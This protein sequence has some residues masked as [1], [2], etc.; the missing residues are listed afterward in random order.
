[1]KFTYYYKRSDGVRR[2]G[3]I[4][5]SSRDDAFAALR[6]DGIRPIKVVADGASEVDG[7]SVRKGIRRGVL[8]GVGGVL[9]VVGVAFVVYFFLR[10]SRRNLQRTSPEGHAE[11]APTAIVPEQ[12]EETRSPTVAKPRPRKWLGHQQEFV[13]EQIFPHP[14]EAFLARFAEPGFM[15]A[16]PE[17]SF[18]EAVKEDLL[19]RLVDDILL[20]PGEDE[21]IAALKRIV[22]GLKREAEMMLGAGM[23]VEEI[24]MR[25]EERQ[26]MEIEHRARILQDVAEGRMT[27]EDA[28]QNLSRIGFRGIE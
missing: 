10:D 14:S 28:A 5:A 17:P 7:V 24:V 12:P 21:R 26:K 15:P 2:E 23:T 18:S 25:F 4:E 1:M 8:L 19:D 3:T 22:A 13:Y 16:N 6:K 9:V 27:R 11:V 20:T